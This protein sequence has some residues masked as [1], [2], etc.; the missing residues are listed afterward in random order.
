M[1]NFTE[2]A[3]YRKKVKSSLKQNDAMNRNN[4]IDGSIGKVF[5]TAYGKNPWIKI[6]LGAT[7][8]IHEVWVLANIGC[9]N[10]QQLKEFELRIGML[11][12][13][14]VIANQ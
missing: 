4:F 8:F 7:H 3:A 11:G 6:D 14:I 10:W 13:L 2:N 12:I 5:G 1:N 9:C